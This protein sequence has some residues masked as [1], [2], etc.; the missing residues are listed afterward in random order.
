MTIYSVHVHSNSELVS[1]IHKIGADPRSAAYFLPKREIL[2]IWVS[3]V[4]FR[5]AAY[6]KQ[7]L[8]ARGGDAIVHKNVIDG[9]TEKSDVLLLGTEGQYKALLLKL[10]ALSCWGLD[11][12]REEL[13]NTFKAM[14]QRSWNLSLPRHRTL[15]LGGGETKVMGILN[16][17]PDSFYSESRLS[18]ADEAVKQASQMLE[19]GADILDIGAES[20]RPG[21][22]PISAKEEQ[23]RLIPALSAVRKEFQDAV[24][25]VDTYRGET[26]RI[27][28]DCGADIINDVSGFTLD[29][30]MFS[31]I[32]QTDLVYV[33]SHIQGIPKTMQNNP[34]YCDVIGESID[35][36]HQRLHTLAEA[37]VAPDRIIIDPGIG[38]GKRLEDNMRVLK[39]IQSYRSLGRPILIGHSRKGFIRTLL[40]TE[41]TASRLYGTLAVSAYCAKEAV[42]LV[43]VHDVKATH[44]VITIIKAIREAGM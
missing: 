17:T 7:E 41:D 8:L 9:R 1:L 39:F 18:T 21:S 38:F 35:Y 36:F 25:S 40:E 20:T 28:S 37:G 14:A 16:I 11:Q 5:A 22:D 3:Q 29:R 33:L 44:D 15:S 2:P 13:S 23:D 24:I 32:V 26:A 4:D 43:R 27:A 12:L 31:A 6:V 19:A 42:E 34:V 10:K 30:D